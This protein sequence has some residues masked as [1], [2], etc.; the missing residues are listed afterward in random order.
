MN[1]LEQFL[2]T[3]L[4]RR[5]HGCISLLNRVCMPI[6]HATLPC[7][8]HTMLLFQVSKE[9]FPDV[10]IGYEDPRVTLHIGDGK[11]YFYFLPISHFLICNC[12]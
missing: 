12:L 1:S 4:N 9:F 8:S 2:D 10:A 5:V 11:I 7:K 6:E 3:L